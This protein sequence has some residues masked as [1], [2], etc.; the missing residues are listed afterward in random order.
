MIMTILS[1]QIILFHVL[2]A[3]HCSSKFCLF[4]SQYFGR[5]PYRNK[6]EESAY[7][8]GILMADG[9]I[10]EIKTHANGGITPYVVLKLQI[11]DI[12]HL[13]KFK[14]FVGSDH[15][16]SIYTD[17]REKVSCRVGF[18]ARK[19]AYKLAEYGVTPRKSLIAEIK[20]GLEHN[21]DFWRGVV[22][23]DRY[24]SKGGRPVLNLLGSER[25]IAQFKSFI[26][27][28][29]GKPIP[30]KSVKKGSIYSITGHTALQVVKT[31]YYQCF[32]ALKR[33]LERAQ[34]ML[35]K[36]PFNVVSTPC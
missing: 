13:K 1:K 6:D 2:L 21:R 11:K 20:G 9:S 25:L 3:L 36:L 12:D 16:I 30:A 22:D 33:K 4:C 10:S 27:N 35:S 31:L 15:P 17:K 24:L 19:M 7:W 32:I 18:S 8:I 5:Y 34:L 29:L 23:G 28:A 14:V 26:E